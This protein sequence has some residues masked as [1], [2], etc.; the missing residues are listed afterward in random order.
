MPN[1]SYFCLPLLSILVGAIR[2]VSS[3]VTTDA[4]A[5]TVRVEDAGIILV[6]TRTASWVRVV[7]SPLHVAPFSLVTQ[8]KAPF[9]L[10]V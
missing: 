6:V 9:S 5:A 4:Y 8:E 2:M 1:N 7:G 10:D 3:S